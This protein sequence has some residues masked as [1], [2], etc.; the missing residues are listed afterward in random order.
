MPQL[1]WLH[2]SVSPLSVSEQECDLTSRQSLLIPC[3]TEDFGF[4]QLEYTRKRGSTLILPP[5]ANVTATPYSDKN[6]F[7][8]LLDHITAL[9]V[10]QQRPLSRTQRE[11]ERRQLVRNDANQPAK[12]MTS[13]AI[14]PKSKCDSSNI[15]PSQ[16]YPNT[17]NSAVSLHT[18]N[19][20]APAVFP[21]PDPLTQRSPKTH[22][23]TTNN[24]NL[25]PDCCC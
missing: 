13:R 5:P 12:E 4:L 25:F 21:S 16:T 18:Q 8:L 22:N 19:L 2:S 11:R 7:S 23:P 24:N 20:P 3:L 9:Q 6:A 17:T 14:Y 15:N 1:S 10:L